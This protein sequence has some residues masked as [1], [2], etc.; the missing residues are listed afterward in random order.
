MGADG[1]TDVLS[2]L[3][4]IDDRR[5][6]RTSRCCSAMSSSARRRR[7]SGADHAGTLDDEL[8][9]ARRARRAPRAR[10]RPRRADRGAAM[11]CARERALLER[12]TGAGRRRRPF[13]RSRTVVMGSDIPDAGRDHRPAADRV[14][15]LAVAE[16]ALNRISRARRRRSPRPNR[17]S[18]RGPCSGSSSIPSGS[19]TRCS[20]RSRAPERPGVPTTLARR[21]AVRRA[22]CDRRLRPQRGRVLRPR[23]V[24]AQDVG[25]AAHRAGGAATARPTESLVSFPPLRLISRA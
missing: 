9:P 18:R 20:S 24:D 22:R 1:P 11:R 15:V 12:T 2:F 10:P 21:P 19:S 16:T 5:R 6:R 17:R 7:E 13:A 3:D 25:G 23:R 8:A 4:S 14:V